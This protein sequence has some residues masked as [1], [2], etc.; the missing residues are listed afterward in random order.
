MLCC[1]TGCWWVRRMCSIFNTLLPYPNTFCCSAGILGKLLGLTKWF[2]HH[3]EDFSTLDLVNCRYWNSG[4]FLE[5]Q[6]HRDKGRSNSERFQ[7]ISALRK[8]PGGSTRMKRQSLTGC[9]CSEGSEYRTKC[10]S[11]NTFPLQ[12]GEHS[13][14]GKLP[15]CTLLSGSPSFWLLLWSLFLLFACLA[16]G[17]DIYIPFNTIT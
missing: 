14:N 10:L 3:F 6:F 12:V 5:C 1:H 8:C 11:E 4:L 17:H 13:N 16:C 9:S 15:T 7:A 2:K